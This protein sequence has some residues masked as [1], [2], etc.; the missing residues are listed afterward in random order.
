M[1]HLIMN[2]PILVGAA[3]LVALLATG[4]AALVDWTTRVALLRGRPDSSSPRAP[5]EPR[6]GLVLVSTRWS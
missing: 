6:P 5:V 3:T 1:R 2:H 4:F